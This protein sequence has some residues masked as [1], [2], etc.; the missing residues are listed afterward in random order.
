MP[1]NKE[2]QTTRRS[3]SLKGSLPRSKWWGS[4]RRS[5]RYNSKKK[6]WMTSSAPPR[7][8]VTTTSATTR[9][10]PSGSGDE[11]GN[12]TSASSPRDVREFPISDIDVQGGGNNGT[13]NDYHENNQPIIILVVVDPTTTK[14]ELLNIKV[15]GGSEDEEEKVDGTTTV[16]A[17]DDDNVN[18]K[19][20]KKENNNNNNNNNKQQLTKAE[21]KK[22]QQKLE[23]QRQMVTIHDILRLN[24]IGKYSKNA[25]LQQLDYESICDFTTGSIIS[26]TTKLYDL[27][28]MSSTMM[29]GFGGVGGGGVGGKKPATDKDVVEELS[30]PLFTTITPQSLMRAQEEYEKELAAAAAAAE[31]VKGTKNNNDGRDPR[32]FD[33]SSMD[34]SSVYT[35]DNHGNIILVA[36]PTNSAPEDCALLA[37]RIMT[38]QKIVNSVSEMHRRMLWASGGWHG[39]SPWYLEL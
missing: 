33:L 16:A 29:M 39:K 35:S 24:I 31:Q 21:R 19:E 17:A 15:G 9:T 5:V 38:H 2:E 26:S 34:S 36:V 3:L 22:R 32:S 4:F 27:I 14:F 30:L 28:S 23:E 13:N 37:R 25:D 8:T 6:K 10:P 1:S 11:M 18:K 20:K 12:P 7:Q